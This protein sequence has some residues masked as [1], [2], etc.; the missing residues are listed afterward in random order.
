[1]KPSLTR[2]LFAGAF[3][4]LA[5]TLSFAVFA[6]EAPP[7]APATAVVP[8]AAPATPAASASVDPA[9]PAATDA[10]PAASAAPTAKA[11]DEELRRLDA[12]EADATEVTDRSDASDDNDADDVKVEVTRKSRHQY[13]HKNEF[14]LGNHTVAAGN[15]VREA[16]SFLGNTTVNGEVLG[17]AVS[18]LGSTTVNGQ[19]GRE[20]VSIL[21]NST[22][23]TEGTAGNEVVTVLG[24]VK[25]DG[26]VKGEVVAVLGNVE[27]GPKALLE[28]S[29][30]VV[31]GTIN[32]DP[33]AIV[34]GDVQEITVFGLSGFD[35]LKAWFHRCLLM[36]RPLAFGADLFWAWVI[37][38]SVFAIYVLLALLFPRAFEKCLET[39]ETRPGY[40]LLT[41]LLTVLITPILVILLVA[42]GVGVLLL[43]FVVSG[44]FFAGIFGKAVMHAWLGRRITKHFGDGPLTHV[45]TATLVG[46][47]LILFLYTVPV[48]GFI[49]WKVLD[50][51]GL[52]VVVY[53]LILSMR[54]EKPAAT[55]P[56]AAVVPPVADVAAGAAV[57]PATP[58]AM[59]PPMI[60]AAT[61]PRAGFWIRVAASFLDV[62]LVGAACGVLGAGGGTP[63]VIAAYCVVLWAMKGT[64]IGGI[65][66]GLKV[67]RLD[68]RPVDWPVAVVRALGAFLSLAVAGLGFIWVAFDDQKQSWHDKI[69]GTTVVRV[70]RGIS[71]L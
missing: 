63:L 5:L 59:V 19:V 48:L 1:M 24:N 54:R 39:L 62:I 70:P 15:Q 9:A 66:C 53:T 60:S 50:I 18:I 7:A 52:G 31:G 69:A 23:N 20:V 71:L 11:E 35:G 22:V 45:A 27:L 42:T 37:A 55:P 44:L 67:V 47:I 33:A 21:G 25:I 43:P 8:P 61:L 2:N 16:V 64:T 56:P 46:S 38:I 68:D 34:H 40:S 58:A 49:L 30:T 29:I 14:P 41:V 13:R 26:R 32:R 57:P 28:D 65:V 12:H 4:A 51:V 17:E 36:G 3:I 6:Q 10:T